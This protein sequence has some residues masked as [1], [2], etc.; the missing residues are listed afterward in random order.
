MWRFAFVAA[1]V[2][3]VGC[4]SSASYLNSEGV[5]AYYGGNFALARNYFQEAMIEDP[6][7]PNIYY[8]L[9]SA[10]HRVG[11]HEQADFYYN[12]CLQR[13]PGHARCHHALAVLY[14]ERGRSDDAYRLAQNWVTLE[15]YRPEPHVELAWLQREGGDREAARLSLQRAL[16]IDPIHSKALTQLASLYEQERPE[17]AV[18][19]YER[20][21]RSNRNQPEVA[22]RLAQL[23]YGQPA[24]SDPNAPR[25]VQQPAAAGPVMR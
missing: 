24:N 18:A 15:P 14:L 8:N 23:R 16:Q 22:N 7:D 17:R 3:L 21:L 4:T 13:D 2:A 20:S 10:C 11:D 25:M 5:H 12:Q 9:A 1:L 19:L 6:A